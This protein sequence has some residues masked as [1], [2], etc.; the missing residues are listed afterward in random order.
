MHPLQPFQSPCIN[1]D[2][3]FPSSVRKIHAIDSGDG[4]H[5]G[6]TL[7]TEPIA[8]GKRLAHSSL[9]AGDPFTNQLRR[10]SLAD[11]ALSILS[12]MRDLAHMAS[13]ASA[14][15]FRCS[16]RRTIK[17]GIFCT[18]N[19]QYTSDESLETCGQWMVNF[20]D[21]Q[22]GWQSQMSTS[23]I[24]SLLSMLMLLARFFLHHP[25]WAS[26]AVLHCPDNFVSDSCNPSHAAP[27]KWASEANGNVHV[28]N[29]QLPLISDAHFKVPAM[30]T[31]SFKATHA[32]L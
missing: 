14:I 5:S 29:C 8:I 18:G 22:P 9:T 26:N 30:R 19:E 15:A 16:M 27:T 25:I 11:G 31:A 13:S 32:V 3:F 1:C 4:P 6:K 2:A 21:V 20:S 7:F 10:R 12:E 24:V 17:E 23:N 28:Q